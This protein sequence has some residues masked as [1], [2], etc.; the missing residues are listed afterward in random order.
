[1]ETYEVRA[2]RVDE[3]GGVARTKRAEIVLDTDLAGRDD[4]FN[5]AELVLAAG[6]GL[7]SEE[8]GA[9]RSDHR[10]QLP[11]GSRAGSGRPP[12]EAAEAGSS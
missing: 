6:G 5:P 2:E 10:V 3:H 4:A 8:H 7:H 9:H 1:M 12:G 11:S